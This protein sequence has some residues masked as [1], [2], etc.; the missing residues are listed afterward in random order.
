[1]IAWTPFE[2]YVEPDWDAA[3]TAVAPV[4]FWRKVKGAA[5]GY[6]RDGELFDHK[7][8][9]ICDANKITHFSIVQDPA[10]NVVDLKTFRAGQ[11]A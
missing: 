1:M 9:Y 7:W 6:A 5:L 10:S 4:L 2:Q 3:G 8:V 11:D